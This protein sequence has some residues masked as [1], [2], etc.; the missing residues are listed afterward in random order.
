M[1]DRH[2]LIKSP[3][4]KEYTTDK[5]EKCQDKK[6]GNTSSYDSLNVIWQPIIKYREIDISKNRVKLR[7]SIRDPGDNLIG[8]GDNIA[9]EIT[10][11]R[12][13]N[14]PHVKKRL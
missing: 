11:N 13:E 2:P 3:Q 10:K 6:N 8:T 14:T 9:E 4:E 12:H 7:D 1:T 5:A